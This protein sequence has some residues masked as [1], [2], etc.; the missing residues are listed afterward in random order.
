MKALTDGDGFTR[1]K[2]VPIKA[3]GPMPVGIE[4]TIYFSTSLVGGVG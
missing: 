3:E 2:L 1:G 4:G